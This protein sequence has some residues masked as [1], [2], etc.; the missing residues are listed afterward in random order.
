MTAAPV[1]TKATRA[2]QI[3]VRVSGA[4][5]GYSGKD[6]RAFGIDFTVVAFPKIPPSRTLT[7][8]KLLHSRALRALQFLPCSPSRHVGTVGPWHTWFKKDDARRPKG[9]RLHVHHCQPDPEF[10][11]E[12]VKKAPTLALHQQPSPMARLPAPLRFLRTPR[13]VSRV[14][15]GVISLDWF[16]TE[17]SPVAQ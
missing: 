16:C 11:P 7:T 8:P 13:K 10:E 17:S 3:C 1:H 14:V 6:Y 9:T 15:H 4:G 5:P 2:Q 12:V